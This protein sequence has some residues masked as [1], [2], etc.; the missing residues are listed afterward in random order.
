MAKKTH[1]INDE[2]HFEFLN[3]DDMAEQNLKNKTQKTQQEKQK[4]EVASKAQK[5]DENLSTNKQSL[6][7]SAKQDNQ[8]PNK[9][10]DE[11]QEYKNL[12][13]LTKAEFDNFRK[14]SF[15][16]MQNAKVEGEINVITKFLPV[17]DAFE[18]AKSMI[19]D[20]NV[21]KGVC[22]IEKDLKQALKNMGVEEINPKDQQFD[23]NLH[24]A[25]ST[26][27]Q[28]DIEEDIVTQVYQ[29]GYKYNGKVIRYAQVIINKPN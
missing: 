3:P 28:Q 26:S 9:A 15:T 16:L 7:Q 29:N 25:I 11:V 21:L 12:L 1:D 22:M 5:Q 14:R 27:C 19:S 20:P 8:E 10:N 2:S 24:N 13:Q 4:Q 23:A 17:L 6:K 18:K